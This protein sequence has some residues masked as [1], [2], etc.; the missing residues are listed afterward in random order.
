M[1]RTPRMLAP[2]SK[3]VVIVACHPKQELA[4]VGYADGQVLLVRLDDG[5]EIAVRRPAT[6]ELSALAWNAAGTMLAFGTEDG[7]AGLLTL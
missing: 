6:S 3:R 5:A 4:D 1:G 2:H 7:D